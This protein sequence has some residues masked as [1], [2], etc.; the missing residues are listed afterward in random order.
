[1]IK[2]LIKTWDA[3]VEIR[4]HLLAVLIGAALIEGIQTGWHRF[5]RSRGALTATWT[6]WIFD[7][8][9]ARSVGTAAKKD[10][11]KCYQRGE[12]VEAR[13]ERFFPDVGRGRKWSFEGKYK[14]GVLFGYFWSLDPK[15][16]SYGTIF[17]R[18][19]NEGLFR[20]YYVRLSKAPINE[21]SENVSIARIP[22]EWRQGES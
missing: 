18:Q 22:L 20:G 19:I 17:L 10:R 9:A 8:E 7:S 4:L 6:S 12:N 11:V 21:D 2:I 1:M 16:K 15:F 5:Q 3:I 14:E 13:I